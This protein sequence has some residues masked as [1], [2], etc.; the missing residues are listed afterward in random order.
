MI[1]NIFIG[2]EKAGNLSCAFTVGRTIPFD[3]LVG[4]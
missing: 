1:E 2:G 3:Y 4:S